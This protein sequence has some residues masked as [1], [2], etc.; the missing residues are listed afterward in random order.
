MRTLVCSGL[1]GL[2]LL[3][4]PASSQE[5]SDNDPNAKSNR[6]LEEL[7]KDVGKPLEITK[8]MEALNLKPAPDSD[9]D[10]AYC[11]SFK[12]GAEVWDIRREIY[13]AKSKKPDVLAVG[14]VDDDQVFRR[15]GMVVKCPG[16]ITKANVEELLKNLK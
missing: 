3:A 14:H 15:V 12:K 2:L 9:L 6:Q 7:L 10:Y 16:G 5:P 8:R 4:V 1:C 13:S 11:G